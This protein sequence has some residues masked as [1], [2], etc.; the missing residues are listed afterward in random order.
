MVPP[1]EGRR[2]GLR[3]LVG[4]RRREEE[5]EPAEAEAEDERV[6]AEVDAIADGEPTTDVDGRPPQ[7]DTADV[8]ATA[9]EDLTTPIADAD[10]DEPTPEQVAAAQLEARFDAA[11]DRLRST[12]TPPDPDDG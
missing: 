3:R 11:R 2:R 9:D 12:I 6:T 8:A 5:G 4:R 10:A 1:P 7:A